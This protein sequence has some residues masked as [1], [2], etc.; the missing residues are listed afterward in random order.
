MPS[1]TRYAGWNVW[2]HNWGSSGRSFNVWVR[3]GDEEGD[4]AAW[5]VEARNLC[6]LKREFGKVDT[7]FGTECASHAFEQFLRAL[8][9]L[10]VVAP[11]I[12]RPLA[13]KVRLNSLVCKVLNT[14]EEVK[15]LEA[16]ANTKVEMLNWHPGGNA[17]YQN[18]PAV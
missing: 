7:G 17:T 2:V 3:D 16:K 13:V 8:E 6:A 10:Q 1:R 18:V 11:M 12:T 9:K 14:L 4:Y 5:W 15:K